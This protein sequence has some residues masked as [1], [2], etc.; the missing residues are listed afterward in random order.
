MSNTFF[1]C[2]AHIN[3]PSFSKENIEIIVNKA[4]EKNVKGIISV[5]ETYEDCLDVLNVAKQYSKIILPGIGLHP[6][7]PLVDENGQRLDKGGR[8]STLDEVYPVLDLIKE[9][10]KEI[11]CIGEVGL[12][13]SPQFLKNVEEEKI[14]QKQIFEKQIELAN[15][16]NIP[17]NVHSRSAGHYAIETLIEKN[18]KNVVLHAFDGKP[19]YA[20]KGLQAGF[21]FSIPPSIK[22]SPQK[23]KLVN[24]LPLDRILLETDSP[25]L[26][27]E[28]NTINEPSN[29]IIS[30]EEIA[31]I[32]NIS[33]E[34]VA[35]ITNENAL[36]LFPKLKNII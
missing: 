29:V 13:Y 33:I 17:L 20:Q 25:A 26:S 21:Y 19:G 23:Q 35:R 27:P 22:R 10:Q 12:D 5:A 14:I 3:S 8:S 7:Q 1:D 18:A 11:V 31:R 30:C 28:K 36:K 2:H 9:H 6:I 24:I 15:E 34:E 16:L 4:K 32:K